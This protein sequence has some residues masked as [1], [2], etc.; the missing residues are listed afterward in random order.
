MRD[1]RPNK[2]GCVIPNRPNP[3]VYDKKQIAS[4]GEASRFDW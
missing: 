2:Y 4:P 1:G 3:C